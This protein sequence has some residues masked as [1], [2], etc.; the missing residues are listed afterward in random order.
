MRPYSKAFRRKRNLLTNPYTTINTGSSH[1]PPRVDDVFSYRAR[2]RPVDDELAK[3]FG[4][5]DTTPNEPRVHAQALALLKEWGLPALRADSGF[6]HLLMQPGKM[7]QVWLIWPPNR[8]HFFFLEIVRD[9]SG[10]PLS[11]RKSLGI[12]S[13]EHAFWLFDTG[14]ISWYSPQILSRD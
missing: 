2:A 6:L 1:T 5:L 9:S 14:N 13:R 7:R 8:S 10:Q 4:L 12:T 3:L 11:M